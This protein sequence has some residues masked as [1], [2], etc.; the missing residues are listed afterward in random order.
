MT[1]I[2][3]L[4]M[5][6][7]LIEDNNGYPVDCFIR[8]QGCIRSSKSITKMDDGKYSIVNEIDDTEDVLTKE[9]LFDT[10]LTNVGFA[11]TN[12]QLYKY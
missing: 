12:K 6:D 9:E 10:T 7:N 11:L 4:G 3:D 1:L 8:L 2:Y 5:L